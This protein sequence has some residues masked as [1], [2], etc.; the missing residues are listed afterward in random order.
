MLVTHYSEVLPVH[1]EQALVTVPVPSV[2]L[3]RGLHCSHATPGCSTA[4]TLA[5]SRQLRSPGNTVLLGEQ[6]FT[7]AT[8]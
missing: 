8:C 6:H 7:L 1:E 5:T 3:P 4:P 2:L